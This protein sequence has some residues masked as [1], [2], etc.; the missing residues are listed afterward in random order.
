[1]LIPFSTLCEKYKFIP[2]G[3]LH[4]GAHELEEMESYLALGV[5]NIIWIEGNQD[6]VDKNSQKI[7]GTSQVMISS[8]V[9]SEDDLEMDFNI[10]NN[11]QSSSLLEFDK[12]KD[13]H[14]SVTIEKIV[15]VKTSRVDTILEKNKI[16]KDR[17]DFVNLDIQGVEMK[18][19]SGFGDYLKSVKYIYTE[20]N[21][22]SVYKNNDMLEDL[23]NFLKELGFNRAETSMT[24]Y[25]WGDAFYIRD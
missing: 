23:D 17:F 25:E 2:R 24:D 11:M 15:K 19:L 16:G 10:T 20:V 3:I 21:T 9:Y 5:D 22:G 6:L 8:V 1:M 4:I 7:A 18:A 12:H 13:Y 14:P